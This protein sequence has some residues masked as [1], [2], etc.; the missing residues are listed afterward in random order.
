MISRFSE[1]F[2][3]QN[4]AYAKFRENKNIAKIS[5]FTVFF[6]SANVAK[7]NETIH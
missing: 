2:I 6:V 5:E 7:F 1:G 4:F 3:S